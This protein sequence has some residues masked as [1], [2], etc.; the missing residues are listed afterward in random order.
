MPVTPFDTGSSRFV[1]GS[2]I[3]AITPVTDGY[4]EQIA[5]RQA[6]QFHNQGFPGK[7]S[8][9]VAALRD[10][11]VRPRFDASTPAT[12]STPESGSKTGAPRRR[13]PILHST[14][15]TSVAS[16]P[17]AGRVRLRSN[18]QGCPLTAVTTA[19]T[20]TAVEIEAVHVKRAATA[21]T[22]AG[23]PGDDSQSTAGLPR[24]SERAR[25][26]DPLDSASAHSSFA[27]R[28]GS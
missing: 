6:F 8:A 3:P 15:A 21:A 2:A 13:L 16:S 22:A 10:D 26:N 7:S 5:G 28:D 18:H 4:L 20:A 12:F 14:A 19:A 25:F 11:A 1:S 27:G 24:P 23:T 17:S 9:P